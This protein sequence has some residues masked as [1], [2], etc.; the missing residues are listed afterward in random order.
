MRG[1]FSAR[2]TFV[3]AV[4]VGLAV[5]VAPLGVEAA[6]RTARAIAVDKKGRA[7][8]VVVDRPAV[9][10]PG[11]V[12]VTN[13]PTVEIGNQPT[14]TVANQPAE[15]PVS[16]QPGRLNAT[17]RPPLDDVFNFYVEEVKSLTPREVLR[18][19]G[20][21]S[22]AITSVSVTVENIG[23]PVDEPTIAEVR[24][25]VRES[26]ENACGLAGWTSTTVRRV[27]LQNDETV[28]LD[29]TGAPLV[30][31][32]DAG[33]APVCVAIKLHQWVGETEVSFAADGY[34]F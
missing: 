6:K 3:V 15:L 11:G 10:V 34:E 20:P 33:G 12:A 18:L 5:A 28:S 22:A 24:R 1:G 7:K 8:V 30:I 23:S 2:Q 9:R 16:A 25:Y 26:G 19:A 17:T 32:P 13:R 14:V 29:L 27:V 31:R 4:G 21:R